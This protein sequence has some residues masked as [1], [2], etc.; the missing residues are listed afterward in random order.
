ME[1][2]STKRGA[3]V[4]KVVF[5]AEDRASGVADKVK[6]GIEQVVQAGQRASAQLKTVSN[7]GKAAGQALEESGKAGER[8][9]GI[10]AAAFGRAT[11][12]I[13]G[14]TAGSNALTK[15]AGQLGNALKNAFI[16]A[17]AAIAALTSAIAFGDK[18]ADESYQARVASARLQVD[19]TGAKK[20]FGGLVSEMELAKIANRGFALGV[21]QNGRE[22]AGL[23]AGVR[24]IAEDL[25]ED[26]TKL[27]D[28]AMVAIGRQ[29]RLI[30]DN[31]GIIMDQEKAQ[32]MYAESLN[33]TVKQL[34]EYEKSQAFAKA[35][36][37]EI[38]AAARKST[39]ANENMAESWKK[40]KISM[41][42]MKNSA[43]GFDM[44][45]GQIRE[46]L[47]DLDQEI[48]KLFG[49]RRR[50]DIQKINVALVEAY[51]RTLKK[52]T[53]DLTDYER[54]QAVNYEQIKQY[55]ID[56]D[57]IETMRGGQM[58]REQRLQLEESLVGLAAEAL[59]HQEKAIKNQARIDK[60][61]AREKRA[62]EEAEVVSEMEHELNLLE[63][64]GGKEKDIL[65]AARDVAAM[66]LQQAEN[67]ERVDEALVNQLTRELE[68]AET[69]LLFHKPKG[70]GGSTAAE[71]LEAELAIGLK[72]YEDWI[73]L[74][75]LRADLSGKASE[76]EYEVAA[77]RHSL[78]IATL[79]AERRVLEVTKAKDKAERIANE[80][81]IEAIGRE[82][83]ILER[84]KAIADRE[85]ELELI[86]EAVALSTQRAAHEGAAAKRSSERALIDLE[87][88]RAATEKLAQVDTFRERSAIKRLDIQRE[89][90]AELAQIARAR[91]DEEFKATQAQFD[92]KEA[93]LR[94]QVVG[95]DPIEREKQ[96]EEFRQLAHEREISRLQ[97]EQQI[98]RNIEAEQIAMMQAKRARQEQ[99]WA[100]AVESVGQFQQATQELMQ[101]ADF[102]RQRA[103]EEADAELRHHVSTLEAKGRAQQ[104]S[105]EREI[106][107]AEGNVALQNEIRRKQA[108]SDQALRKQIELAEAKHQDKIKRQEMRSAG[109]ALAIVSVVEGVKA[110]AAAASFNVVEALLHGI[111]STTAG[112]QAG[113]LLSGRIPGGGA[114]AAVNASAGAGG[115]SAGEANQEYVDPS[116]V[117][118]SVPGQAARRE[119]S[120]PRE[121]PQAAGTTIVINGGVNAWGSIDEDVAIK[122][123]REIDKTK[124]TVEA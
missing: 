72:G 89:K 97:Y 26:P 55:M 67:A 81:R 68:L 40:A 25:G 103:N 62:K 96:Q 53:A 99:D 2:R 6:G 124:N 10:I 23:A 118:G 42:D 75:E 102:R 110:L 15:S 71:R 48:L 116:S 77:Q 87:E 95:D 24:A 111:A 8:A 58:N 19:I 74:Q 113:I 60:E 82:M 51:A 14:A 34:T 105:F 117:P 3:R 123:A 30:L 1:N 86:Q 17:T 43:F 35:A 119:S 120:S 37:M 63:A 112:V 83:E 20:A 41:E 92:A 7:D 47:R 49:S 88:Q 104:E 39:K 33:K 44:A 27:M 36:I 4:E 94:S 56:A 101:F 98:R 38:E 122:L 5:E 18:M 106:A 12:S 28:D 69:Q 91:L 109:W 79:E 29:S 22:L 65:R 85:R 70:G 57:N 59:R 21:V 46:T 9:G 66:K 61:S 90:E 100:L 50:E 121:L 84:E 32:Q 13:Q 16:P 80:G 78:A 54:A 45:G 11:S 114:V 93:E 64:M 76:S 115:M 107:A 52:S 31:L 73:R 108:K